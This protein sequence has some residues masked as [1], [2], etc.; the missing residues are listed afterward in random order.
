MFA[1]KTLKELRETPEN[2]LV[3]EHDQT[4]STVGV[5]V[6]YYLAELHRRDQNRQTGWIMV[7]TGIV[8]VATVV[9]V[10]LFALDKWG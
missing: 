6:E 9:N 7:M 5:G 3:D 2:R 8:T 1:T 10:G 4:A